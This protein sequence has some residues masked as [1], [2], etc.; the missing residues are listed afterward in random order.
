MGNIDA[1]FLRLLY[2]SLTACLLILA[3]MLLRLVLKKAPKWSRCVMWA[4]V[5]FRLVC[6]FTIESALSLIPSAEEI[7]VEVTYAGQAGV[8]SGISFAQGTATLILPEAL[9]PT[10]MYSV[11]PM[12]IVL[13]AAAFL[14][15][16]GMAGMLIY[17]AASFLRLRWRVREAVCLEGNVWVCDRVG[18]PFILGIFRPKIYLPSGMGEEDVVHVLAHER[19]HLK[20]RDHWWKPLGFLILTVHWFNPLVWVAYVLLCRDIEY[21]CDEKVIRDMGEEEKKP[22]SNALINCAAQRKSIAACPL[23]FGE[24]GVKGRIKSVLNY[25]KPL[26]W[27]VWLAVAACLVLVVCFLTDPKTDD[28][29]LEAFLQQQ[30][31][32]YHSD[33]KNPDAINCVDYELLGTKKSGSKTIVYLCVYHVAYDPVT[34]EKVGGSHVPTVMTVEGRNGVYG[35][36]EHWL[37][38]DGAYYTSSIREKFPFYL[39]GRV[40]DT[41]S[42]LEGHQE[43]CEEQYRARKAQQEGH[44]MYHF[45]GSPDPG[46]PTVALWEGNKRFHFGWS[47]YSSYLCM[48]SYEQTGDT[49]TLRTDDGKYTF[50]FHVVGETLVFDA[51]GSSPIPEYRYA[52]GAQPRSPVPDGAVFEREETLSVHQYSPMIDT[53]TADMDGDGIW[54]EWSLSHGP[55]SGLYTVRI[56]VSENGQ[57]E[58]FNIFMP[59]SMV[60]GFEKTQDGTLWIKGQGEEHGPSPRIDIAID[61]EN[62]VLTENGSMVPYWGE[63]G[64]DSEYNTVEPIISLSET[65]KNTDTIYAMFPDGCREI[66]L[67][68]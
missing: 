66:T 47:I 41:Q 64:V 26:F 55:T 1:V 45:Y 36:Y 53:A 23:A 24:V 2:M 34:G 35:V 9:A 15:L 49:L 3:V 39:W 25:K 17:M 59:A 56:S 52:S 65:L 32:E 62:I 54:E 8:Q 63:Q 33:S 50:I 40:L 48:G 4:I 58:Y 57:P 11:D 68:A 5:A 67:N 29:E 60:V 14:W 27:V 6:P 10:P 42:C 44:V 38:Q 28:S 19:A 16:V 46:T 43:R 12:Q 21:A 61:G 30:I 31:L 51:A 37:P 13:F 7:P 22:Y 20:R 18:S